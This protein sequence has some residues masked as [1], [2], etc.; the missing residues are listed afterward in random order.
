MA[1]TDGFERLGLAEI[2]SFRAVINHRWRRVMERLEM[3][4]DPLED[5]EQPR[6]PE[7]S[8]SASR[9]RL[10]NHEEA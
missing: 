1:A 2:V 10:F 3:S 7:G 5:F 4:H 8:R 6:V 9:C